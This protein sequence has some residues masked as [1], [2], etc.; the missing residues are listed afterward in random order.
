M[1][2]LGKQ[3]AQIND[4]HTTMLQQASSDRSLFE[5]EQPVRNVPLRF[6]EYVTPF[7]Y[8]QMGVDCCYLELL[9]Q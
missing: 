8:W 9:A 3:N 7:E 4:L 5:N 6:P 2:S 1:G